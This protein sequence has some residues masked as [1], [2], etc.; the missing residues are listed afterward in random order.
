MTPAKSKSKADKQEAEAGST[1]SAGTKGKVVSTSRKSDAAAEATPEEQKRIKSLMR[2][3]LKP[4]T[5]VDLT[6]QQ[7]Q[8]ADEVLGNVV[9]DYVLKRSR[10]M[11]TDEMLKKHA[12]ALKEAKASESSAK[13]QTKQAFLNAGF[14]EDQIKVFKA[15]QTSLDKAKKE[16]GQS[17]SDGQIDALPEQLQMLIKGNQ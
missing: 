1:K 10:V 9:K 17:L 7:R 11:I 5:A 15:T 8:R 14:N 3:T 13:Q 6:D 4:F 12:A 16:F 2:Q